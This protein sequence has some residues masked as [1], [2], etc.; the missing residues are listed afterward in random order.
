MKHQM[1]RYSFR[2]VFLY[3]LEKEG[4]PSTDRSQLNSDWMASK[5][6]GL[7]I[8]T[9][10][11]DQP[12]WCKSWSKSGHPACLFC[13]QK[14]SFV[15]MPVFFFYFNGYFLYLF[16]KSKILA[17]KIKIAALSKF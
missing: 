6:E 10:F 4:F 1:R 7:L 13:S 11:E 9:D 17:G 14:F 15:F 5:L 12:K 8:E 3:V 16:S 2:K